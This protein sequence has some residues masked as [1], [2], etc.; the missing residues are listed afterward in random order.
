MTSKAPS[1]R[2]RLIMRLLKERY[3]CVTRDRPVVCRLWRMCPAA[4]PSPG[5]AQAPEG[6]RST[7]AIGMESATERYL[8]CVGTDG[9]AAL[10]FFDHITEGRL[11]P[12]HLGDA[13]EDFLW[14]QSQSRK[15]R[16]SEGE[17]P[18]SPLQNAENML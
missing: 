3:Y 5:G 16:E 18:K 9:G 17:I 4:P 15:S 6:G 8:Y 14:E 12:L 1:P 7:Y 11:S 10:A 2:P 13:V